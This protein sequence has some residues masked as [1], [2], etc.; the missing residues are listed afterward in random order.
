MRIAFCFL[1]YD[2]LVRYDIWN[3]FFKNIDTNEYLVTIHSKK[4]IVHPYTFPFEI[5]KKRVDTKSKD[6]ISIVRATLQLLRESYSEDIS[7]Y[8]FLS[9]SCIPLYPFQTIKNVC[10]L[11]NHSIIS[12]IYNNKTERYNSLSNI[13]KKNIFYS[14]FVKQQPNM[15]LIKEDV[16]LLIRH[17]LT[18]HFKNMSC[19]D[20]HYFINILLYIFKKKIIQQQIDFCNPLLYKT[21]AIEFRHIDSKLINSIRSFGFLFMRKVTKNGYVNTQILLNQ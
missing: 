3:D 14:Q 21:Q 15:I 11:S 12:C 4:E 6:H 2:S 13:L 9:Q 20:E 10:N 7:H 16:S 5:T 17:D 8:I 19:P 1:T 18:E